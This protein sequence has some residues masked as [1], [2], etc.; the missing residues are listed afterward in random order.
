M[1]REFGVNQCF[2]VQRS[3]ANVGIGRPSKTLINRLLLSPFW[4]Y[5]PSN[6]G[7]IKQ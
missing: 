6:P 4:T 1:L 7:W 3:T 2:I 5:T